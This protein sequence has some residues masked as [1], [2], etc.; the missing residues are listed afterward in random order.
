MITVVLLLLPHRYRLQVRLA[1]HFL[2]LLLY[3]MEEMDHQRQHQL[4][5]PHLA[6]RRFTILYGQ[7]VLRLL[8]RQKVLQID[9]KEIT[10][11]Q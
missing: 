4:V 8:V 10:F 2:L 11:A 1:F 3:V 7:M 6:V 5:V 9:L